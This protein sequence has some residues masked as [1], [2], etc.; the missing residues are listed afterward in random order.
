MSLWVQAPVAAA[1]LGASVAGVV[2]AGA[3]DSGVVVAGAADAGADAGAAVAAVPEQ[4]ATNSSIV[5]MGSN[6]RRVCMAVSPPHR[7][8]QPMPGCA[9]DAR[10]APALAG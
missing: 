10:P 6:L 3:A 2:V 1:A 7:S 5:A 8:A 9:V 4:P